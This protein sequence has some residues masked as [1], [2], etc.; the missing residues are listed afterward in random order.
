MDNTNNL[1]GGSSQD[2]AKIAAAA[3]LCN[4]SA[5]NQAAND[6]GSQ[7]PLGNGFYYFGIT[8]QQIG[9]QC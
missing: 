5:A 3:Q 7:S 1:P 4:D 9:W 8:S 2:T 6:S